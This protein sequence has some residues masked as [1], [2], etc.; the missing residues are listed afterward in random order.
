VLVRRSRTVPASVDA[1]WAIVAD[2][3]QLPRWW[4]HTTRVEGVRDDGWT[5]VLG[6]GRGRTVRADFVL[7]ASEPPGLVR[8]AQEL[9]G[10][11]FERLLTEAIT[12]VRLERVATGT[13]VDL[14]LRQGAR[15]WA[16]LGG[17][18]LRRAA[19]RQLDAA[20]GGLERALVSGR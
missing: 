4:P 8:W 17:F 7:E 18:M 12:E 5:S 2:P 3:R 9:D 1:V 16:M 10:T 15:G 11:P 13:S 6:S 20:L 14:S 19:V